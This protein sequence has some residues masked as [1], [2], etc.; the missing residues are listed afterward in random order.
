MA[1]NLTDFPVLINLPSDADLAADARDD[2]YDLLFT[3]DDSITKLSHEI[4][5]FDGGSGQLAAW[6]KVPDLSSSVDTVLYLYYG[7]PSSPN[8]QNPTDVWSAD[9]RAVWHLN[10]VFTDSTSYANH[11][12]N[13]GTTD[14]AGQIANARSF[15]GVDNDIT[16]GTSTTLQPADLTF[17]FW[18][19]RTAASW[20]SADSPLFWA[21]PPGSA[22][23]NGWYSDIYSPNSTA[24]SLV[25]DGMNVFR[26]VADID[27]FYPQDT[28]TYVVVAFDSTTDVG[29]AYRNAVSQTLTLLGTPDS[30]TSTTDIKTLEMYNDMPGDIDEVHISSTVRS[31]EWVS[32]EYNNQS[33][34]STFYTVSAEELNPA[35]CV[36]TPTSTATPT[37][38]PTAT[39]T[40]TPMAGSGKMYWID[41][42]ANKIQRADLDGTN[43]EDLV[44]TGLS[45]AREI[46]VDPTGGMMYW[47]DFGADK[48]KSANLDGSNVQVIV[49]TGTNLPQGIALDLAG[50]KVYWIDFGND[51]IQRANLDG[52]NIE[53]LVTTGLS[54][55]YDIALDPVGGKMYWIDNG[56]NKIQRSNLDGSTV[57]DLI[58]TGLTYPLS[59][60]LDVAGGKMYWTDQTAGTIQRANLDGTSVE[61]V[62]SGL[63]NPDGL[64]LDLDASKMYWTENGAGPSTNKIRRA[65]TDGTSAED[66]IT[67]GLTDPVSISLDVSS[68]AT[69]TPAIIVAGITDASGN[70]DFALLRYEEDGTLDS[71]FDGDGIVTTAIGSDNDVTRDIALQSDGK[72]VV[73]G[74]NVVDATNHDINVV[75]YN[76]DGSLDTSF[77][78]NGI[79]ILDISGSYDHANAVVIQPDGKI[80]VIGSTHNG[81]NLDFVI[82]RYN[83]DGSLDTSFDTNGVT[84]L[85]VNAEE[86][87]GLAGAVQPDGKI[88]V[89]GWGYVGGEPA[90]M[91]LRYNADGTLDNTFH[92]NGIASGN[93]GAGEDEEAFALALQPDGKILQAG[94]VFNTG[95][96]HERLAVVRYNADGTLD[97]T[98][99]GDGIV[100][101]N[102]IVGQDEGAYGITLQDDDKIVVVGYADTDADFVVV[103]YN[104]DGSLDNSFDGD[105]ILTTDVFSGGDDWAYDV[106]IQ[107]DGAIVVAG[108]GTNGDTYVVVARY[109]PDGSLD[110]TFDADGIVT[111]DVAV[112]DDEARAVIIQ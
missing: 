49:T 36:S 41:N 14:T 74:W 40:S 82:A 38:T 47:T 11:G 6:V 112:G 61:I 37:S 95:T 32:T 111:T 35:P 78:G 73:A 87:R 105:G 75:R 63:A 70:A 3:A 103:R 64:D 26:V 66:L 81:T 92:G 46:V 55:P 12:T 2:G 15:N 4:E 98:F 7:Y 59:I 84:T 71:S 60:T 110:T 45:N 13:N 83:S 39:P 85:D 90:F 17:S 65:N 79:A 100:T 107:S 93:V 68:G 8:Q 104:D 76:D 44:T 96:G 51:I 69:P 52:T 20:G 88:V 77:D 10:G 30:I 97:T 94:F 19:K 21:K 42:G 9:Y 86:N 50:G 22:A 80:V 99:D 91:V 1:A 25:T 48:I 18:I 54:S 16:M 5:L 24:I 23:G 34:P 56:A 101:T 28:W 106:E 43:V 31:S 109:N 72:Y 27:T 102:V 53:D 57:E 58:T 67:T 33:S 62:I 89:G 108:F 29:S